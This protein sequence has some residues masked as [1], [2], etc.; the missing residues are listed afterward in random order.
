MRPFTIQVLL[1]TVLAASPCHEGLAQGVAVDANSGPGRAGLGAVLESPSWKS[2][3]LGAIL[4]YGSNWA[5]EDARAS[6][7]ELR[8]AVHRRFNQGGAWLG[9]RDFAGLN[10]GAWRSFG[11]ATVSIALNDRS[12]RV[13][14]ERIQFRNIL[15]RDSVFTDSGWV[16]TS[17][18]RMVADS[19]R[20]TDARRWSEL[21]ARAE[22]SPLGAGRLTVGVAVVRAMLPWGPSSDSLS[23][24]TRSLWGH[25]SAVV[26]VMPRLSL[27]AIAG[28]DP[29]VRDATQRSRFVTVGF[30]WTPASLAVPSLPMDAPRSPPP[31]G[32]FTVAPDSGGA[33]VVSLLAPGARR[34][35]IAGDFSGWKPMVMQRA[36]DHRWRVSLPLS[37]G[38]HRVNVRIDGGPWIVPDGLA[39]VDD[40]FNGRVGLF[41]VK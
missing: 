39:T 21:E 17:G 40:E 13:V 14:G 16:N 8:A 10:A 2:L 15:V 18:N 37:A 41:V 27:V 19:S 25:V 35:E 36:R 34:V 7:L 31:V 28:S 38:P 32:A 29:S 20:S 4:R 23:R 5:T 33:F 12:S 24:A 30:R 22:W 11:D 1:A 9:T 3:Q 26:P 6:E